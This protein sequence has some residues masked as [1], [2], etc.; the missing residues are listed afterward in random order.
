MSDIQRE[1]QSFGGWWHVSTLDFAYFLTFTK[2]VNL[3]RRRTPSCC[4]ADETSSCACI[5]SIAIGTSK[6]E[7]VKVWQT[8]CKLDAVSGVDTETKAKKWSKLWGKKRGQTSGF[9]FSEPKPKNLTKPRTL[10]AGSHRKTYYKID[11]AI[12]R[13]WWE[14][15]SL[16]GIRFPSGFVIE[17]GRKFCIQITYK[18][19]FEESKSRSLT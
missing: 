17:C 6:S 3:T 14:N 11:D 9:S 2:S 4:P 5:E 8:G 19:H 13:F 7:L 12:V 18:R 1:L 10:D 15:Q 16:V